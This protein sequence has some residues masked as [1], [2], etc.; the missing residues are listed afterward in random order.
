LKSVPNEIEPFTATLK[1]G[2]PPAGQDYL[3][4]AFRAYRAAVRLPPAAARSQ[5]VLYGNLCIGYHEQTRLQPE[6][7]ASVDGSF[8]DGVEVKNRLFDLLTPHLRPIRG[9]LTEAAMRALMEPLLEPVVVEIQNLVRETI[10]E[11]LM[12][13]ELPG[14]VLRL[15]RDLTGEYC[16]ALRSIENQDVQTL[17]RQ[18]D[19]TPDSLRGTG[20]ANWTSF[21]DRMHFIADLFRAR[22]TNVRLFEA[23]PDEVRS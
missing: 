14:E 8:W 23:V 4:R 22:Q 17:L 7:E 5:I 1:P 2:P 12:V 13:L 18:I 6:I 21:P 3:K 16:D 10:T 9:A 15:G 20:V 19:L 11:A